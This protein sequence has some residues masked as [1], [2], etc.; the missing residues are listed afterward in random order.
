MKSIH[1][2]WLAAGILAVAANCSLTQQLPE[3]E[4]A[5]AKAL[6]SDEQENQIG[7]QIHQQL[8]AE[9]IKLSKD[10]VVTKYAEG[11]LA[12]L[13]PHAKKDRDTSWHVHVV[14]DPKTVNAFATPGGHLYIYTGLLLAADNES[15]VIGVLAHEVG[16][17][18]RRHSARQL[19]AQYGLQTVAAVAL[20]QDANMLKQITAAVVANG[21]ILAHSRAD[22][23]E[24][25]VYA[26]RYAAQAGYDPRGI[27]MF[28]RK[29]PAKNG[30]LNKVL[31]YTQTHPATPDRIE[32]VNAT[33]AR[34]H[35]AGSKLGK[36]ELDALKQHLAMG[37]PVS[38]R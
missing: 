36:P 26:V 27:A 1:R 6:V 9:G 32:K 10:P 24:A 30:T 38:W 19:V 28:F 5:V 7:E 14:E 13:T 4:L 37:A 33:I 11:L 34:E 17:V 16:H 29:L 25:D 20:G 35:L 2:V 12:Q 31:T 8:N 15:E 23:N 22:E 21:A 18:V 3:A